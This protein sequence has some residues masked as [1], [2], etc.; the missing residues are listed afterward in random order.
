MNIRAIT[1][2]AVFLGALAGTASA[3]TFDWRG[4]YAGLDY[5]YI[6]G[7]HQDYTASGSAAGT[8]ALKGHTYGGFAGYNF[9]N[10]S[11]VYG[12]ELDVSL[13][14]VKQPGANPQNRH[15]TIVDLK[16]RAGYATGN[17]LI[18]GAVGF[19]GT[20]WKENSIGHARTSGYI[21]GVG[22]DY[23]LTDSAFLGLE[24]DRRQLKS[25]TLS[26]GGGNQ[27]FSTNMN[28]IELRVGFRF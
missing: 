7:G 28:S 5:T 24:Y 23:A 10:G 27:R 12:P 6:N 20:N 22:M 16:F 15:N 13:G 4:A 19:S 8:R 2:A 11:F 1:A 21:F 18:Y 3:Q 9:Q 14:R 26:W 17:A 25:G